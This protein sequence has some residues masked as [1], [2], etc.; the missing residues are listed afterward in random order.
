[1]N[2]NN[3]TGYLLLPRQGG[4]DKPKKEK[5]LYEP[6]TCKECAQEEE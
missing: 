2:D 4:W 3:D 5:S 6:D 1:M